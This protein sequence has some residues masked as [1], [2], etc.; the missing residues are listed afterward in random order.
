MSN[1]FSFSKTGIYYFLTGLTVFF[2]LLLYLSTGSSIFWYFLLVISIVLQTRLRLNVA[3]LF[4]VIAVLTLTEYYFQ[5]SGKRVYISELIYIPLII[6]SC[7]VDLFWKPLSNLK[8]IVMGLAL[9]VI[10]FQGFNFLINGDL[11]SSIFRIRCMALPLLL[12]FIVDDQVKSK[13]DLKKAINLILLISILAT[14]VVYLQFITGH[15]YLLQNTSDAITEDADFTD[16]YLSYTEDSLLF[17]ALGLHIKGPM[18][19]VGLNYFKFGYSEKIIVPAIMFFALSRVQKGGKKW[20]SIALYV[21]LLFATLLTGSRSVLLTL[22]VLVPIVH[23][24]YKN[25]LKWKLILF[26]IFF[27]FAITY[28]IAPVLSIIDL[29]ELGTLAGRAFYMEDFFSF[30]RKWPIALFAGKT[31]ESYLQLTGAQQPPHHFLSFGIVFDGIVITAL[32]FIIFYKFLKNTFRLQT[33]DN[34]LRA[35]GYG[36][37]ASL[38]GFVFI[39]GQTSYL[40]WSTPHNMFFCIIIGLLIA[41]RRLCRQQEDGSGADPLQTNVAPQVV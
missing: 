30:I 25:K 39:Y 27:F 40:T 12:I 17:N 28:L 24:Q 29:D 20:L 26:V 5:F 31:P 33:E 41:T 16:F 6:N 32:L 4:P 37:W 34:E 2:F 21:F 10:I 35:I 19:P 9:A 36:L 8:K 13:D 14:L 3:S 1:T 7:V 11:V 22:L 23:L 15:Y 38:F 18:P